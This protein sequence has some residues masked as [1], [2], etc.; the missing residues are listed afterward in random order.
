M[1]IQRKDLNARIDSQNRVS[2]LE[3]TFWERFH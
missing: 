2:L 1:M 3:L